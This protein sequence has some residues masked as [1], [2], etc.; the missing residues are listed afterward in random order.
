[1][2][3][4]GNSIFDYDYGTVDI[5]E[6]FATYFRL[7]LSS[8]CLHLNIHRMAAD[9][10][11]NPHPCDQN[12]EEL[13]NIWNCAN[14]IWLTV[15]SIM[16]QGCDILPKAASTRIALSFW[17]FFALIIISSYTAN[18]AA[19]LTMSRMGVT[20]ESADDLAKQTKIKYGAVIG[21][22]TL[23]F[24]KDSNF[25]TYQRMWSAME[26]M[27][28]SPFVADNKEGIERVLKSKG[29]YAFIMES[30]QIEYFTQQNCNLTQV[31]GLLDSKGYGIA[32]PFSK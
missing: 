7:E 29:G 26:S 21:G 9:D 19:F 32:L 8:K 15:G 14:C 27:D 30:S 2:A 18:L 12:P 1:M 31:G 6:V 4:Y 3:I 10:W 25:S 16:Q 13:E 24:F 22:S 23:Q 20:I 17:F 5:I 28:P 11:E